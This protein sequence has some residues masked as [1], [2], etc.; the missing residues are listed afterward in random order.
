MV[1][2]NNSSG[3]QTFKPT[4]YN[5]FSRLKLLFAIGPAY[6][7]VGFMPAEKLMCG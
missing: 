1:Q 5:L 3:S 2:G 6:F 4:F 7:S